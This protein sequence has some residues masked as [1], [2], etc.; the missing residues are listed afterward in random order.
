M[1]ACA[2]ECVCPRAVARRSH[3]V[4]SDLSLEA[5]SRCSKRLGGYIFV[6]VYSLSM[7]PQIIESGEAPRA[8]ALEWPFARVLARQ[9]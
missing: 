2:S 8:V 6:D 9:C 7:L 5:G 1:S 4:G 3:S